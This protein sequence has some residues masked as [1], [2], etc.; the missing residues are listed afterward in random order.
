MTGALTGSTSEGAELRRALLASERL[1]SPVLAPDGQSIAFVR[2]NHDGPELWLRDGYG[3]ERLLARHPG[4]Q[5]RD[6]RWS[7]DSSV[8][9]Y[10]HA[11]R[12]REL[13]SLAAIRRAGLTRIAVATAASVIE[14]WL[15][16]NDPKAVVYSAR[17]PGERQ[18]HLYRS[19]IAHQDAGPELVA[20]NPGY[21]RWLVDGDLRARGGTRLLADGSLAVD[22]GPDPATARTALTV[23]TDSVAQVAIER[24]S[25]DG[26]RLFA[27]I[28]DPAGRRRL[29]SIAAADGALETVFEHPTLDVAGYPITGEGVWYS[30]QTGLPDVCSVVGQR[31]EYCGLTADAQRTV[32]R[33]VAA[34]DVPTV[35]IDRSI[36]GRRWLIVHVHDDGPIAY[37]IWDCVTE[38]SQPLFVNR[39]ELLGREL[40]RLE[41]FCFTASDDQR[42]GGYLMRPRGRTGAQPT[43]LI[44]HGGPAS[45]DLW[46]FHADAQYLASLGIQSLHVNYRGSSGYGGAF[47]RAGYGEWGGRMQQDLYD[48][49]GHGV[50]LGIVDPDR[51]AVFGASYGGYAA[52][53][54]GCTRPDLVRCAVAVSPP[55]DLVAFTEEPPAFW[56][57]LAPQLRRQVIG[58]AGR[59]ELERRSPWHT[60]SAA[61]SPLL[62]AHGERD[63]R[64]PIADVD[65]F[66]AHAADL[67]VPVRYLRFPDEGHHIR[68]NA[69]REVLFA[70]IELFMEKYL[71]HD[72]VAAAPAVH[73]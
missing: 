5:L 50:A 58:D 42:I 51:V 1:T 47:R 72:H 49:I 8:L 46:R 29:V 34:S 44:V 26:S 62:I 6:I 22:L 12:G 9:F 53:L 4:E 15:S 66:A 7:A 41:D 48:A 27:L 21:H 13:W 39:P 23:D 16:G 68:A 24:F 18:A 71:V 32:D 35:L 73:A 14:Y 19:T 55:C 11:Q 10:R 69:N 2:T 67:G 38:A 65:R 33:M 59:A 36:D 45:R 54:A 57:P 28:G 63:P 30:P 70:E 31:I 25:P 40:S 52:L 43:V 64:V 3:S 20:E 56:Q 60:L 17:R 37:H 61:S